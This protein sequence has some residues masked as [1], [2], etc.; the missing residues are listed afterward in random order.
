MSKTSQAQ[1]GMCGGR[2]SDYSGTLESLDYPVKYRSDSDCT[3]SLASTMYD[4]VKISILDMEI[5]EDSECRYDY[6]EI[7][8]GDYNQRFC[9]SNV[10]MEPVTGVGIAR[11]VFASDGSVEY[12][13]WALEYEVIKDPCEAL[14]C[15]NGGECNRL[16]ERC[17]CFGDWEGEFCHVR[18]RA[19]TTTGRLIETTTSIMTTTFIDE[20]DTTTLVDPAT[21]QMT[22]NAAKTIEYTTV[23]DESVLVDKYAEEELND[24][25]IP[26]RRKI[27]LGKKS[28]TIQDKH[29]QNNS[30]LTVFCPPGYN[31]FGQKH[32]NCSNNRW[33]VTYS[34]SPYCQLDRS[35]P[36][37]KKFKKMA[38]ENL[39]LDTFE[40]FRPGQLRFYLLIGLGVMILVL[41]LVTFKIYLGLR[42]Q[43][44]VNRLILDRRRK[45]IA[46]NRQR[47]ERLNR[48][49][50]ISYDD[51]HEYIFY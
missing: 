35:N 46:T 11:I 13:G 30:N 2:L 19:D 8:I 49:T 32:L 39:K 33:N 47:M 4:T 6:L 25:Q 12:R 51:D 3:Y 38:V 16:E 5:E 1:L 34:N 44:A 42:D 20:V 31:L 45:R 27:F 18:I 43:L 24:D 23:N 29:Y 48:P 14:V 26:T 50:K 37:F 36:E 22:S 15:L 21:T 41:G 28:C 7:W 40:N 9:G 17:D 10:P